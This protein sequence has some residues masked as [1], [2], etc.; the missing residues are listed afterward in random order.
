MSELC[1]NVILTVLFWQT[2]NALNTVNE[3]KKYYGTFIFFGH[4]GHISS[5]AITLFI[6]PLL[7]VFFE[8]S[9][10]D[11][12]EIN[13]KIKMIIV[14]SALIGLTFVHSW[15]DRNIKPENVVKKEEIKLQPK[16]KI[17]FFQSLK[18]I[19][20]SKY[21]GLIALM[22]ICYGT[23][24]NIVEGVWK[25]QV[26]IQYPTSHSYSNFMANF[27]MASG[28]V[29]M[30]IALIAAKLIQKYSWLFCAIITPIAIFI[31][32][33]L[34]FILISFKNEF[35]ML[36]AGSTAN[37][38]FIA[39]LLGSAQ[40]IFS[41]AIKYS[42]FDMTKEMSYIP[43]SADFKTRGKAAADLMG[44]KLG[45]SSGAFIQWGLL[46]LIPGSTLGSLATY[47]FVIFFFI[48]IIWIW[49]VI[50]LNREF[51]EKIEE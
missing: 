22:V 38:V 18:I 27:Q 45:K 37:V 8:N 47:L 35:A 42:L 46:T 50:S 51:L 16:K 49:A 19:T 9:I 1:G 5:G 23:S 25:N 7:S 40:N 34:F 32:G 26:K 48:M 6:V 29:N 15:I 28:F 14:A 30:I 20:S 11:A 44:H 31:S 17:P 39:V 21:L 3:A 4:I 10:S 36:V 24:I 43:L 33:V 13:L 2:A 41:K 12:W